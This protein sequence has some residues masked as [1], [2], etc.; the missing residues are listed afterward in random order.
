MF[1]SFE[2][3][4]KLVWM[5]EFKRSMG[6]LSIVTYCDC[7]RTSHKS[8]QHPSQVLFV[9]PKL[10]NSKLFSSHTDKFWT[11]FKDLGECC[12]EI[13][14]Q[15][16]QIFIPLVILDSYIVVQGTNVFLNTEMITVIW[17]IPIT[18]TKTSGTAQSSSY[19]VTTLFQKVY[20]VPSQKHVVS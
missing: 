4:L 16:W 12:K 15:I 8:D 1:Y 7:S 14:R 6:P 9:W 10:L 11:I 18:S 2:V 3:V 17:I 19:L 13:I 20:K 5:R